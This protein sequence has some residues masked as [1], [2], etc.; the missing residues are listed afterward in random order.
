MSFLLPSYN[1][2]SVLL[3]NSSR[4]IVSFNQQRFSTSNKKPPHM[5]GG[6]DG[7]PNLVLLIEKSVLQ[8]PHL[9]SVN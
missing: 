7:A 9:D 5:S 3:L 2:F 4:E 8:L 6:L 1:Q